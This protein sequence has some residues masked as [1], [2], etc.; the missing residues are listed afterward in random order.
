MIRFLFSRIGCLMWLVGAIVLIV[1]ISAESSGQHAFS[2]VL[3]GIGLTLVG[4]LLWNWLRPRGRRNTRF[5]MF[6][7]RDRDDDQDPYD[8][9]DDRYDN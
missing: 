3:G 8:D 1:G 2:L 6:R 7:R 5:S 4:F 9:W